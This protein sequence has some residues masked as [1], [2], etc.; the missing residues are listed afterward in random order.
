MVWSSWSVTRVGYLI[1]V[2]SF[3]CCILLKLTYASWCTNILL[4]SLSIIFYIESK[5]YLLPFQ[6]FIQ[7]CQRSFTVLRL[8]AINLS[9]AEVAPTLMML[10][11]GLGIWWDINAVHSQTW[12]FACHGCTILFWLTT[13]NITLKGEMPGCGKVKDYLLEPFHT[14]EA[15]YYSLWITP[16]DFA[17]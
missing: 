14:L 8:P 5:Q 1:L 7:V 12:R 4:F 13:N 2:E 9:F 15:F 11:S 6:S 3:L 10:I 17:C 16:N